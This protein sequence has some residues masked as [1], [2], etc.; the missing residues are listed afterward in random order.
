[1]TDVSQRTTWMY[2][3]GANIREAF[4]LSGEAMSSQIS[5]YGNTPQGEMTAS[6]IAA[7]NVA[8][9]VYQK[10]YMEYW[11]STKELT[12]TGRP[13][14]AL[15][16]PLAPFPAARPE[17]YNYYGYS[18]IINGLDYTSCVIPVTTVDKKVDVAREGEYLNDEDKEVAEG[19]EYF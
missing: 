3:G 19:C 12:G 1:M 4:A 17:G 7:T 6:K 11:N 8:K 13:A 15:I 18:T 14:D 9:R 2:D 10:E 5:F 16:M